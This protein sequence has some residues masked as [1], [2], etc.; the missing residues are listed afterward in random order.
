MSLIPAA[1]FVATSH[2]SFFII[3]YDFW[4]ISIVCFIF[5]SSTKTL[6]RKYSNMK[7]QCAKDVKTWRLIRCVTGKFLNYSL[8]QFLFLW[9]KYLTHKITVKIKG[10]I[11]VKQVEFCLVH[12]KYP[13]K[14]QLFFFFLS[15]CSPQSH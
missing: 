3:L 7:N 9:N 12:N 11:A 13:I 10:A 5:S 14:A 4:Y 6:L 1:I 15:K 8:L 2:V